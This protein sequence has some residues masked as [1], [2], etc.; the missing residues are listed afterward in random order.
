LC[1]DLNRPDI[2]RLWPLGYLALALFRSDCR[3]GVAARA[4]D[5]AADP[6]LALPFDKNEQQHIVTIS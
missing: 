3:R 6:V 5:R 4:Y 2:E 1:E